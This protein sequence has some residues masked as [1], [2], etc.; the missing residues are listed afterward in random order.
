MTTER[1]DSRDLRVI[2][3]VV[4]VVILSVAFAR[5]NFSRAFPQASI[6]LR[7]SKDQIT[8]MARQFLAAR[9]LTPDGFR[10]VTIFDSDETARTYLE[11][12]LGLEE[13]NKLMAG[14]VSVWRWR[15]RWFKPPE[16]EERIVWLS[17]DGKLKGFRQLIPEAAS[18][19][20]LEQAEALAVAQ[21][22]L[23]EVTP[24]PH[25]LIEQQRLERP[26]RYDYSFTWEKVGFKVKDATY[27]RSVLVQ[28]DRVGQY[29][30]GLH[31]PEQWERDY[32]ALRSR[33]DLFATIAN[34][35]YVPLVLAAAAVLI[36]AVRRRALQWRAVVLVSAC[37]SLLM[38]LNQWNSISFTIDRMPTSASFPEMIS[39]GV[40]QGLGAGVLVFF[41]VAIAA[42][43]GEPLYREL[44]PGKLSLRAAFSAEGVQTKEFFLA[45]VTGYGLAAFHIGFVV[46]FYIVAQRFGAWSPQDVQY[47]DLLSTWAPWLYPLTISALAATSE[48]FWFRL[49]GV[50]LLQRYVKVQ[51]LAVVVPAFV[52]GF[53]HSNYPQQ[54]AWIRGVEVGL[55][56][57]VAG[58]IMLRF[59][60]LATL[61]WHYTVDAVLIGL[62]LFSAPSLYFR[63][64]GY[65]VCGVVLFPLAA[66]LALYFRRGGFV[67]FDEQ[68]TAAAAVEAVAEQSVETAP[69]PAAEPEPEA[70]AAAWPARRLAVAAG[71]A[72]ALGLAASP[73]P[74]GDFLKVKLDRPEARRITDGALR[75]RGIDAAQWRSV[76]EYITNLR[77]QE[78]E[79]L[80][81]QVGRKDANK[82]VRD[83]TQ[84]NVWRTTYFRPRQKE[85]W[86]VYVNQDGQVIRLDHELGEDA[87]GANIAQDEARR[88]A[89]EYLRAH[90][91]AIDRYKLV[92]AQTEK[93]DKRTDHSFVWESLDFH[94]GEAKARVSAS[95]IGNEVS[96][97]R[98]FVKLPEQWVRE[99]EKPRLQAFLFPAV[100]GVVALPLLIVFLRRV[101]GHGTP[102]HK[103]HWWAYT[104]VGLLAVLLSG[105]AAANQWPTV[106]SNYSTDMPLENYLATFAASRV[107]IGLLAG[108][109]FFFGAMALDVFLQASAGQIVGPDAMWHAPA[110][111]ALVWGAARTLGWL[112]QLIPGPRF[113]QPQWS[114]PGS[115]TLLPAF[116]VLQNA[117]SSGVAR[118]MLFGIGVSALIGFVSPRRRIPVLAGLLLVLAASAPTFP[119]ALFAFASG[120][121]WVGVILLLL[122]TCG[123]A[124]V[125]FAVALF[126]VA[127][128]DACAVLAA[129]PNLWFRVNGFL[130]AAAAAAIGYGVLRATRKSG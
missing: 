76:T 104:I 62:F 115:E 43:A 101:A 91:V 88:I 44:N 11:R 12:E 24:E 118:T 120:A 21:R 85:A 78:F 109:M 94:V 29:E 116:A 89:E 117:F 69:A 111:A 74:L 32:A 6:D 19:S 50:S 18:G 51:W 103:F 36:G 123:P 4:A 17:P 93:R 48:E 124:A 100:L 60:I 86:Y 52:W 81:R 20:R 16:K 97:F 33:N 26:N 121:I 127:S 53:L 13:A 8:G 7:Y 65:I 98:R 102:A 64:S 40:L 3:A 15:A 70:V 83:W 28:G 56:G 66:S 54:P 130:A 1:L 107:I 10:N 106:F 63:V 84:T 2:A 71:V 125:T 61:V 49:F 92:D 31:V 119:Q 5:L 113:G 79:Y 23:S 9:N 57:V 37:V 77:V 45:T 122:R 39:L 105:L 87:P 108:A 75:A 95:V 38:V 80:R 110:V 58:V 114:L 42:A 47:S 25:R 96:V 35:L 126:W 112:E 128:M 72:L 73:V 41:Y 129:Q 59:G 67:V 90:G 99:F 22:F 30:E 46:A 27:R 82:L 55:I 14:A 68:P 34:S